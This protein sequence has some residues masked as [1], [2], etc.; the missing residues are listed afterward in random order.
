MRLVAILLIKIKLFY[1]KSLLLQINIKDRIEKKTVAI[2]LKKINIKH[3][4]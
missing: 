4:W 3:K 1:I 2:N